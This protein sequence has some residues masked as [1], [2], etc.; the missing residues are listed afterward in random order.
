MTTNQPLGQRLVVS[1]GGPL[2]LGVL[3]LLSC[4]QT[5][6]AQAQ[7]WNKVGNDIYNT[8]SGKVGVGTST[9]STQL[10]VNKG[11]NASTAITVDN[12]YTTGGN[13][14][15]SGLFFKQAGATRFALNS[16][17]DGNTTQA[18]GPG[19]IH[20]WNFAN[21]PILFATNNIERMRVD[22]NGYVGIATAGPSSAALQVGISSGSASPATIVN[23]GF[24][25]VSGF[26]GY[27]GNWAGAGFWGIGPVTNSSDNTLRIG[28]VSSFQGAWS[29]AQNLNLAIGGNLGIGT[30]AP[31]YKLDL[32]GGQ[33]NSSGGFC[34]AG[35]CKTAWSQIGG[36]TS[37]WT[38]SGSSIYYNSGNAGL[39]TASPGYKFDVQGGQINSSG[40]FCIAG[41][42][43]TAWSQIGGGTSQWTTSGSS[44]YYNSGNIGVGTA[45]PGA[46]LDVIGDIKAEAFNLNNFSSEKAFST[47]WNNGVANQKVQVYWPASTQVDGI[48]EITV[49]GHYWFSNSNGGIRK[50]IVI[51]GR[52]VGIINMEESEVPFRM[53]YTGNSN[54]I[55]NIMWDATNSRYYF[56]VSN[57]D[58]AQN[59]ITIHVKSITPGQT[60][61]NADV[62]NITPIYT[63]DATSYPQLF[64][65]FMS[66]NVGIGTNTP[67]YKLDVSGEVN[68]TGFRI[69][70]V[71]VSGGG[72]AV[73]SVFGRTG[74]VV[75]ATNDYTWA[76]IN[77]STSS[78][79]DLQ[80]R[81][82]ADL[83][84]GTLSAARMPALTGD[85][86]S[87]AGG[88]ATALANT[89]VAPGSYTNSNI[90][91][92]SKGRITAASSGTGTNAFSTITA[93]TN[94]Q[95][96]V[97]GTGG[98]LSVSGSGTINATT[99]GGGT[100]AAPG[101]IGGTTPGAGTFTS[102]SGSGANLTALNASNLATGTIATARLGSGTANST[103]FLRGDNTWAATGG[104]SQWI[105][106]SS[107][108][109]YNLGNVGI[110]TTSPAAGLD[111]QTPITAVTAYGVRLQQALT[112]GNNNAELNGLFINT[113]FADGVAV[114][115]R[116]N[117]LVTAAGNVGIGS[118]VTSA[119]LDVQ[120]I[121]VP[122]AG[123][124]FGTRLQQVLPSAGN[125]AVS[126]ALYINPTFSDG[127][128]TGVRHNGLVVAS[129][130]V[131][132]GTTT[133]AAKLH[134]VGNSAM[135]GDLNVSG[136][137]TG[138]NIQAKYQDVAE[139]VESSQSLPAG[140]VVVLDHTRS[141]QV[142]A[143]F[144]AY[145]TLVAGVISAQPGIAL[146]E[147]SDTKV[148]VATTGRVRIK[149]DATSGAIEVGDLLVTSDIAGLAKKSEPL[150][151]AGVQ[152]HRPGTLIGKALEPLASGTGEVLVL[153]SLQ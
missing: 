32:Q 95:A 11:Q 138:G 80:I 78:L 17:N 41:D 106:T 104:S 60:A 128:A 3:V 74:A 13:T 129:G 124:T 84:S 89:P 19:A 149:V 37:Q 139:W 127:V 126:T 96:L 79:A 6:L 5:V 119:G 136:T 51:N 46:K 150:N 114:G 48:Y 50:R 137:I 8:N 103:T 142:I 22:A 93:G 83:S 47:L 143:S 55:S 86:T 7:Q 109:Y 26:A 14:A 123:N 45:A 53:G 87:S 71:P 130:D 121:G 1:V 33:I 97:V 131:G 94:T 4:S 116:H 25:N 141:N 27:V 105:T 20:F 108:I 77:K 75:A 92:D 72:G 70:G 91:V 113:S 112:A 140:T 21:A 81:S 153:L 57:L 120:N 36:G 135:T 2:M 61:S 15:Y 65:S 9:P 67:A 38:T 145:D 133:P 64:T 98:S 152:I 68:A 101:A 100:F 102:I 16:I 28:N 122:A 10:E 52:N 148:L 99:L 56:I 146:G 23:G 132:I 12:G 147:K 90:T 31:G 43:K 24:S 115:V 134:V 118:S 125:N 40:G 49:T 110:G 58:N 151:L 54:T 73:S 29:G 18:G 82:A 117:A 85:I 107:N 42:C 144:K 111:V 30:V 62:L 76:Q 66:S 59:A 34:I 35:D 44:I 63:T 88:V 39:G 69:N